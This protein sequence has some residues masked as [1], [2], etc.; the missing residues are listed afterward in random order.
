MFGDFRKLPPV[1]D[2]ALYND[3]FNDAMSSE[4]SLIFQTFEKVVELSVCHRQKS[5][6]QFSKI[7]DPMAFGEFSDEDSQALSQ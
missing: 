1:R 7:L 6:I 3:H 4:G 5:D 2:A